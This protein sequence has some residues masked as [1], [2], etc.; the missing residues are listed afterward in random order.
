MQIVTFF[1]GDAQ[2]L[3]L[4]RRL[5]L[6]LAVF[7]Q[8]HHFPGD[9]LFQTFLDPD[10][11][12]RAFVHLN[13]IAEL[14]TIDIDAALGHLFFQNRNHLLNLEFDLGVHYQVVARM[15][16][17]CVG[18]LEIVARA[19]LAIGLVQGI[20]QFVMIDFGNNIERRHEIL[21][22]GLMVNVRN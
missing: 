8:L 17:S 3:A 5:H 18:S 10:R 15:F 12:P 4:D 14:E 16:D 21:A 1:A 2:L 6:H 9:I 20:L 22:Q 11:L 13:H 7:N 19:N